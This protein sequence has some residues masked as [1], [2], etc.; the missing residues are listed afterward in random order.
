MHRTGT[1]AQI[2]EIIALFYHPF[3]GIIT[4]LNWNLCFHVAN[5]FKKVMMNN[6]NWDHAIGA[7]YKKGEIKKVWKK[8]RS[9]KNQRG[10]RLPWTLIFTAWPVFVIRFMSAKR[11]NCLSTRDMPFLTGAW[12]TEGG[13]DYKRRDRKVEL[14]CRKH[15]PKHS[16]SLPQYWRVVIR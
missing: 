16:A 9:F 13:E 10:I 8:T 11:R 3:L 15:S 2:K 12:E 6:L 14:L 7:T 4:A 1:L 5:H